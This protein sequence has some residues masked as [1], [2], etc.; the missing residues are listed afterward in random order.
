MKPINHSS[1]NNL[2][3]LF[4]FFKSNPNYRAD[5]DGLRA[6]ACLAVVF[7]HAF[8]SCLPGGFIGVDIFFVI[9]GYL[10]SSILYRHLFNQDDPGRVHI[11]DFYSRR[12]RRIFP[13]LILVLFTTFILGVLFLYPNEFKL[14]LKH[15]I[16]GS[17]YVS[18]FV[19]YNEADDYF[20]VD[21]KFKPLLHLWSLGVE[22]QFY[23]VFPIFLWVIYK[24]RL[25]FVLSLTIFSIVSFVLNYNAVK[26][27]QVSKAF[28]MPWTRF[29]ELSLGSVLSY[30]EISYVNNLYSIKEH[31]IYKT[32]L[33]PIFKFSNNNQKII[34]N[35]ISIVGIALIVSG[36]SLIENNGVYPGAKALIPVFGAIFIIAGG[37][38]AY[39][40]RYLLANKVMVFLGLISYPLYLWHWP[41]LSY[42]FFIEGDG[43]LTYLRIAVILISLLLAT[44]TL[45]YIEPKLRYGKHGGLK[46]I[47]L[48]IVMLVIT[49]IAA[50]KYHYYTIT[51]VLTN[52]EFNKKFYGGEASSELYVKGSI[53]GDPQLLVIGDS[54]ALQYAP[55]FDKTIAYEGFY[56]IGNMC[57][58]HINK[59]TCTFANDNAENRVLEIENTIKNS[60][61]TKVMMTHRYELYQN[62]FPIQEQEMY[63]SNLKK[64]ILYFA[65]EFKDKEF[66]LIEEN[67]IVPNLVQCFY[68]NKYNSE[69]KGILKSLRDQKNKCSTLKNFKIK[70]DY[71]EQVISK[72]NSLIEQT[73]NERN[74]LHFIKIRDITCDQSGCKL[75]DKNGYPI[76]SDNAHLSIWGR[77]IVA[78]AILERMNINSK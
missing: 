44:V 12:V 67:Y 60:K 17:T 52:V 70:D 72:I 48:F 66:Y 42:L 31:K 18:N 27:G 77:D 33:T 14:V 65:D 68:E 32:L 30:I 13:A 78:P 62:M 64:Q 5:I 19:L 41:L 69:S 75:F 34:K 21:S 3:S 8:P 51:N 54:Y 47:G 28:F 25:N 23:L 53:A 71:I 26:H 55:Y 49:F 38:D 46:A 20:N 43:Q 74:N 39:I 10:I 4:S 58:K 76:F 36:L 57:Y 50:A 9:S 6:V 40:N 45:L 37:K 16:G 63:L 29:W 22:E 1:S 73:S 56:T 15:I 35:L 11:V 61:A 24:L 7:Y 59:T 2:K